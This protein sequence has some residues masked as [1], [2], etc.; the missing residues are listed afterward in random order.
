MLEGKKAPVF[1]LPTINGEMV[2][3]DDYLGKK[4]VLYFYSKDNTPGWTTEAG[5]F[6]DLFK[7]FSATN[8][9]VLGVS[10]DS[11]KS[12]EKF[13]KKLDLNFKLLSDEDKEVHKMY[14]TWKLKKMFGKEYYGAER[15]TFVI[16]ESGQVVKV[17]RNVKAKGHAKI[18]LEFIENYQS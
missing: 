4:I 8:T 12:H 6:N 3:L 7:G 18:V 14:D 2:S 11:L 15:S 9:V 5:E 13:S 10:K 16:D 17:F 1:S